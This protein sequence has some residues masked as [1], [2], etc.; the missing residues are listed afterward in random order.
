VWHA[1]VV[2]DARKE[3]LLDACDLVCLP[4]VS[5]AFGLVYLEGWYY[6]AAVVGCAIPPVQELFQQSDGGVTVAHK[7]DAVAEAIIDLLSNGAKRAQMAR[8]GRTF[9]ERSTWAEATEHIREVYGT[10]ATYS[11]GSSRSGCIVRSSF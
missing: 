6:R 11:A 3:D 9:A 10:V 2:T 5:E 1:G 4:S 8:R 7:P